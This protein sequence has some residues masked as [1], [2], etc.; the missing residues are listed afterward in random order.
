[1]TEHR[2]GVFIMLISALC[3]CFGQC[4]WKLSH[5]GGFPYVVFGFIL[6]GF[7][8]VAMIMAYRHGPVSRLQPILAVNYGI[9][10]FLGAVTFN[11]SVGIIKILALTAI[12]GGVVLIAEQGK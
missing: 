8:A 7:G 2:R 10:A 12:T 6:C 9:S 5:I 4:V 3:T 1:M 11:E